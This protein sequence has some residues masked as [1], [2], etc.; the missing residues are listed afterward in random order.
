M[1]YSY[2]NLGNPAYLE[3]LLHR[4]NSNLGNQ[5]YTLCQ[6][7]ID[8]LEPRVVRQLHLRVGSNISVLP[9]S[10]SMQVA[11]LELIRHAADDRPHHGEV[12]VSVGHNPDEINEDDIEALRE[13]VDGPAAVSP[14]AADDGGAAAAAQER[15][16]EQLRQFRLQFMDPD[17]DDDDNGGGGAAAVVRRHF[18]PHEHDVASDE[19][20]DWGLGG[21]HLQRRFP[22]APASAGVGAAAVADDV[23][24]P[25][26]VA[27]AA[28]QH[29]TGECPL[30]VDALADLPIGE[31]VVTNCGHVFS[32]E[33]LEHCVRDGKTKCPLCKKDF[34][35]NPLHRSE[36]TG[37]P[38]SVPKHLKESTIARAIAK[39]RI[40][41]AAA[42]GTTYMCDQCGYITNAIPNPNQCPRCQKYNA[43]GGSR[44][45]KR[46]KK[47]SRRKSKRSIKRNK[48][49]KRNKTIKR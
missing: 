49:I 37:R 43:F 16:R 46:N 5:Y 26:H 17:D 41:P 3:Y 21:L 28:I 24:L 20:D 34:V 2:E 7:D 39:G 27:R 35:I 4:Y 47:N 32:K 22:E 12:S 25:A 33:W 29:A 38:T 9:Y 8:V 18:D 6:Q 14:V 31:K 1:E 19:D 13:M 23:L 15:Q 48:P 44:K 36:V 30:S 40:T 45:C 42:G 11:L 10:P